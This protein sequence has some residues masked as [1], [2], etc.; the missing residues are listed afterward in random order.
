MSR[1]RRALSIASVSAVV[2]G[3]VLLAA[4]P[5][6][7]APVDIYTNNA[8]W[9]AIYDDEPNIDDIYSRAA[10]F[11]G[12]GLT[13]GGWTG[14][15]LDG[16]AYSTTEVFWDAEVGEI[17]DV[18]WISGNLVT[19]GPVIT[20]SYTGTYAYEGDFITSGTVT[21]ELVV[22]GSFA[23]WTFQAIS[24]DAWPAP[25]ISVTGNTGADSDADYTDVDG[26][27]TINDGLT[28]DMIVGLATNGFV[29]ATDGDDIFYVV[30]GSS[31]LTFTIAT[32]DYN[33]CSADGALDHMAEL[34][35]TFADIFGTDLEPFY[36]TNC[37][38]PAQP[39]DSLTVG[40]EADLS[41]TFESGEGLDDYNGGDNWASDNY[42]DWTLGVV[43]GLPDGVDY[44][45]VYD[46]DSQRAALHLTGTP[47]ES[48]TFTLTGFTYHTDD[49]YPNAD[50]LDGETPL[51]FSVD[52]VVEEAA[53]APSA[54]PS[55]SLATTGASMVPAIAG[56]LLLAAGAALWLV[57][58]RTA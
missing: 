26:G 48:G 18:T 28:G 2:A 13:L 41:L 4:S 15:A 46:D 22:Q 51:L 25:G 49:S 40:T 44:E 30:N 11:Q 27:I 17:A 12:S 14:D 47:T 35:P 45:W 58:R 56:A 31:T 9:Y 50:G 10:D 42:A 39:S 24:D 54:S 6:L 32:L 3:S 36:N 20:G 55:A 19:G 33:P 21:A 16:L 23:K 37:Y 57:R 5:A 34:V 8:T 52:I 1:I 7:A 38:G 53:A 43:N 29:N